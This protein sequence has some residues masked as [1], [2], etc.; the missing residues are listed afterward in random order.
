VVEP[1]DGGNKK[2]D[3]PVEGESEDVKQLIE[4]ERSIDFYLFSHQTEAFSKVAKLTQ[5]R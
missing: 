5:R 2:P 3:K 4:H 1:G